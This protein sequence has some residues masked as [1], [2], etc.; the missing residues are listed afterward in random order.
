MSVQLLEAHPLVEEAHNQVAI[1]RGPVVYCLESVDLPENVGIM[2]VAVSPRAQFQ[3]QFIKDL[4][5]G[6]TILETKA[7]VRAGDD[8]NKALYRR[9][10]LQEPKAVD[11]R[12]IPYYAWG[13]RGDC[14][15]TVWLPLR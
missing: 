2:D 6:V 4:L 15:M 5:G 8:W 7:Y 1:R 10:S 13:N 14:E 11:I 9:I 3:D 12:L